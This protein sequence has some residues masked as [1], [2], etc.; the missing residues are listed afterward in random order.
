MRRLPVDSSCTNLS[1]NAPSP[2]SSMSS[3]TRSSTVGLGVDDGGEVQRG[4]ER[5]AD[6]DAALERD[7]DR[8]GDGQ[9]GEEATVLERATEPEPGADLRRVAARC[10]ARRP[11]VAGIMI[12]PASW[13][14]VEPG[15]HVEQGGLARAVRSDEADDL[16]RASTASDTSS[17][18][19]I[20]PKRLDEP[21]DLERR[22]A[23]VGV[24]VAWTGAG[25]P[26]RGHRRCPHGPGDRVSC[27]PAPSRNTE[28]STSG[29]SSSSAVGP[30]NR[31]S[32]FSMKYAVSA[33]VSATFTDCSTRMIV[34]PAALSSRTML[35]QLAHDAR[36][37]PE[38]ELVDHEQPR[39]LDERHAERQHLLL[40]A[41][42][43]ARRA[44]PCAPAGSGRCSSTCSV[45]ARDVG[46]VLAVQPARERAGSR[47][48]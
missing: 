16:A 36:C 34:V 41:G 43:V 12:I 3:S 11:R 18:A 46:L 39:L 27:V 31:I 26:T 24:A 23:A 48:R 21:A 29:R 47:A 37:E 6:V 44:R 30:W 35:E 28:R 17:S 8:L 20:P 10:R 7:R 14:A 1:R 45:A 22:S 15:D 33:T 2:I 40:A 19:V 25:R 4:G 32:P 5:V 9:R 42:E 38:R 13:S